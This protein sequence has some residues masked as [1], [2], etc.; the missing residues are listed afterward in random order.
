MEYRRLGTSGLKVSAISLGAWINYGSAVTQ[1]NTAEKLI[2]LAVDRGINFLVVADIYATGAAEEVVGRAIR[3]M[4]RS[5][6]VISTKAFW[7]MSENVN[8]RGLSRKHIVESVNKSLKRF[9]LEYVD[10]FFCH[11]FDPETP[12]EETVRAIDDLIRQG[13]IHYWGTSMWTAD[14]IDAA[15]QAVQA[16]NANRPVVEQPLYNM[17]DREVVEGPLEAAM[18]SRGMGLVVW[19]PL[20]QG[21]LTGKYNA[22]IP[23]DS[24][25]NHVDKEWFSKQLTEDRLSRVRQITALAQEMG[26][27]PAALAIAGRRHH[28]HVASAII[29]ATRPEQLEGNLAALDVKITD[30][31][32]A[33]IEAILQNKPATA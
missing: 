25:Y 5:D 32:N 23:E 3:G 10:I 7:P 17:L 11:R 29:G 22:G 15:A 19:S 2:H 6:L 27:T 18:A 13:K 9:D 28:P 4:K 30:E 16:V 26:T 21:V 33:R 20:A 31:V 8:D 24:R 1:D 12:V 14:N